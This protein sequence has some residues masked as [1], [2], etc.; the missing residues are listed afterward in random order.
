MAW[1]HFTPIKDWMKKAISL[2]SFTT[3]LFD[4]EAQHWSKHNTAAKMLSNDN[5]FKKPLAVTWVYFRTIFWRKT[6]IANSSAHAIYSGIT[7]MTLK[8]QDVA[9]DAI[10]KPISGTKTSRDN[11]FSL[12]LRRAKTTKATATK[13]T[14]IPANIEFRSNFAHIDRQR[15]FAPD[16]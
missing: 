13:I 6:N 9:A 5:F 4:N 7:I 3:K 2:S 1:T 8:S 11:R 12:K 15:T 10:M 14:E 16:K